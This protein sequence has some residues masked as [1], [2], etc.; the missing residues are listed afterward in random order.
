MY[1]PVT[2]KHS[3][4]HLTPAQQKALHRKRL[5]GIRLNMMYR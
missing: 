3:E 5:E 2:D 1:P 4:K